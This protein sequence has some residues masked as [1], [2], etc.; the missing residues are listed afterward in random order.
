MKGWTKWSE[1]KRRNVNVAEFAHASEMWKK[2]QRTVKVNGARLI[3]IDFGDDVNQLLV[4]QLIVHGGQNLLQRW[5]RNKTVSWRNENDKMHIMSQSHLR[6][7]CLGFWKDLRRTC[8]IHSSPYNA[9]RNPFLVWCLWAHWTAHRDTTKRQEKKMGCWS[10]SLA[11]RVSFRNNACIV[12]W[13]MRAIHLGHAHVCVY[14]RARRFRGA[15]HC[16][17]LTHNSSF[18]SSSQAGGASV[19]VVAAKHA[20]R[21]IF[22]CRVFFSAHNCEKM[23]LYSTYGVNPYPTNEWF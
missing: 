9:A 11:L 17:I 15:S 8:S 7:V 19:V 2:Q 3:R 18:S 21:R 14:E 5:G 23:Y 4:R 20:K 22:V 16:A 10:F 13:R 1:H 6:V 12:V